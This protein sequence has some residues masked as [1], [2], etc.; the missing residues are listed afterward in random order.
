[1]Q[2]YL[3]LSVPKIPMD[4]KLR[5]M[6]KIFTLLLLTAS[7]NSFADTP[8]IGVDYMMSDI[9]ISNENATPKS[10]LI[11]AGISNNNMAFEAHYLAS[12][13]SD[14]IYNAEFN[15]DKSLAL[16]F[17]MQSDVVNGF[18]I[19]VSVGYAKNQV[20]VSNPSTSINGDYKYDGF[21]WG[22]AM[23]QQIPYLENTQIRLGYQ[24]LFKGDDI[25]II[26]YTLGF[27]YHF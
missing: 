3:I 27:V 14:H 22:V 4:Y 12:S 24:S 16:Y 21:S 5:F 2:G 8:Y 25:E 6:E 26:G 15:L 9:K 23:H 17:V 11:R 13:S 7:F 20:V 10:A 18:G 19:D 1:M